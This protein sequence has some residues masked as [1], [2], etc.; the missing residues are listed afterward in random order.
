MVT[1]EGELIVAVEDL[2]RDPSLP[3]P[4]GSSS[5]AEP[6]RGGSADSQGT[7]SSLGLRGGPQRPDK[8]SPTPVAGEKLT[9]LLR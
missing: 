5:A 7:S 4:A 8:F 3:L 2:R 6:E 1:E 9:L